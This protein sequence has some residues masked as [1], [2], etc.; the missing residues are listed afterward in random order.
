MKASTFACLLVVALTLIQVYDARQ[1]SGGK[2]AGFCV[3]NATS[4]TA[5]MAALDQ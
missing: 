3:C 5:V 2:S 4:Q 1:I